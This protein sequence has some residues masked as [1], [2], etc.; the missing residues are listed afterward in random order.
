MFRDL[1]KLK[2]CDV[3]FFNPEGFH[4]F[5][6]CITSGPFAFRS[7]LRNLRIQVPESETFSQILLN[8]VAVHDARQ[9]HLN[10]LTLD[11][12]DLKGL[13][14]FVSQL[15]QVQS[16]THLTLWNCLHADVFF[17]ELTVMFLK[18]PRLI[19]LKSLTAL[20]HTNNQ[21]FD[22]CLENL[23]KICELN[24][25]NVVW[26]HPLG[27]P[28][29]TFAA[30]SS[31]AKSLRSLS[32]HQKT[33]MHIA[34]DDLPYLRE[35]LRTIFQSCRNLCQLGIQ[36]NEYYI[37]PQIWDVPILKAHMEFWVCQHSESYVH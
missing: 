29:A 7:S 23:Y 25:I 36:V 5:V 22:E 2:T 30:M 37:L 8:H 18:S 6:K 15:T 10:Q 1:P 9:L 34:E 26:D 16:L 31:L 17:F 24:S 12:F 19:D 3:S 13:F 14:N 28:G 27:Q 33:T 35:G 11:G 20:F 21:D 4:K 32:L